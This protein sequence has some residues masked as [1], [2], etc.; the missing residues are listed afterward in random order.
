MRSSRCLP[1]FL[2]RPCCLPFV[3]GGLLCFAALLIGFVLLLAG[4]LIT[5][6]EVSRHFAVETPSNCVVNRIF[7]NEGVRLLMPVLALQITRSKFLIDALSFRLDLIL[8]LGSTA[9]SARASR[10][11][12]SGR[13]RVKIGDGSLEL[14]AEDVILS[15]CPLR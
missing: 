5:F 2:P 7:R 8:V 14:L 11:P 15:C 10:P 13:D 4:H 12:T 9:R 3:F 6:D 1:H